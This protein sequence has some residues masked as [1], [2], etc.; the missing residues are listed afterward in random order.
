M[1]VVFNHN[2]FFFQV[3]RFYSAQICIVKFKIKTFE[4][5]NYQARN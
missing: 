3:D 5:T 2:E 4:V 1:F